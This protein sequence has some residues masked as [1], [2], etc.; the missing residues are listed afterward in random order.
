[1]KLLY[2]QILTFL[3]KPGKKTYLYGVIYM[4]FSKF[5]SLKNEIALF[6]SSLGKELAGNPFA[7]A[8]YL[9]DYDCDIKKIYIVA[10][11]KKWHLIKNNLNSKKIHFVERDS[12]RYCFVL[13]SA[14]WLINDNVFPIYFV[15][16]ADQ[17]YLNTWHGTPLKTIGRSFTND[18]FRSVSNASRNFMQ[19]THILSPNKYTEKIL[20]KDY[21][22]ENIWS[23]DVIESG[24]PR[25]DVLVKSIKKYKIG[26]KINIAYLPTWRGTLSANEDSAKLQILETL[27]LLKKVSSQI[28][29]NITIWVKL[30]PM[31]LEKFNTDHLSNIK[32]I[33]NDSDLYDFLSN[34][35]G[36]ITDYSSVIF[37]FAVTQRAILLYVPDLIQYSNERGLYFDINELPFDKF[38]NVDELIDGINNVKNINF[39]ALYES[40]EYKEFKNKFCYADNGSSAEKIYNYFFKNSVKSRNDCKVSKLKILIYAGALMSNGVTTSFKTLIS[41]LNLEEYDVT[42]LADTSFACESSQK[43]FSSLDDRIKIVPLYMRVFCGPFDFIRTFIEFIFRKEINKVPLYLKALFNHEYRRIFGDCNFD[44]FVNF[45]GYSWKVGLLSFGMN[46]PKLIYV[47]NE[48]DNEIKFKRVA[49]SRLLQLTY[50]DAKKVCIVRNGVEHGYCHDFYDYSEKISYTPNLLFSD[51]SEKSK[52]KIDEAFLIGDKAANYSEISKLI[53]SDD[54][55]KF[56]NLARFSPEKGQLR[57]IEAFEI[58][59]EK[60][61]N[62]SLFI[63]GGHGVLKNQIENRA[64][65]SKVTNKIFVILG[66]SNPFPLLKFMNTFIFSSTYEGIGLV[67]FEA[68]QLR[69]PVIST[70]IPGPAEFLNQGYGLVVENSIQGL[71][72]G[73]EKALKNEIP[74]KEFDFDEHNKYALNQFYSAV[75]SVTEKS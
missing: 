21:M 12:L 75:N 45:N 23:G 73:M 19:S 9:I 6:E 71:V 30:H 1:M 52:R 67:M 43:Y 56:V 34:M 28:D 66:S 4:F 40:D 61:P 2:I 54:S 57:L 18:L 14:K 13:A 37:D 55:F 53:Y 38:F 22:L 63:I 26:K 24:Y 60:Y 59:N 10:P 44:V 3:K 65:S 72:D 11:K 16:R 68:L 35:D 70:D 36:L 7:I 41:N 48:M 15:R 74:S 62:T 5:I 49:N 64:K 33:P 8:K 25:N 47:H 31:V 46:F 32:M 29:E 58:F 42:I 39:N 27:S 20:K 51:I 50:I 17:K 69:L